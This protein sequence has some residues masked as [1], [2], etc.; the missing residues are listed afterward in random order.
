MNDF[1]E[2]ENQLR[3][4]RPLPPSA[5]LCS[6]V[7]EALVDPAS[8]DNSGGNIVRPDR[9]R[10]SWLSLGMGL[11]AAAILLLFARVNFQRSPQPNKVAS[12]SPAPV[13]APATINPGF[14]P[15][16]ATQVVYN[17]RDD[18]LLFPRGSGEPVRRVR[19][20]LRDTLQWDNP[21]T[22]ASLRVSYPSEQIELIPVSGQ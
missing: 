22:G 7:E 18:G 14:I 4:L 16:G 21:A 20:R 13:V 5:E 11:A 10:I 8:E 2:I 3:Q 17:T 9:F 19:S 1:S 12:H 15:A 6:R